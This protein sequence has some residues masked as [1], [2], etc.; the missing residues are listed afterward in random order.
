MR[1]NGGPVQ[2]L[3]SRYVDSESFT[4]WCKQII[5]ACPR[6]AG[7]TYLEKGAAMIDGETGSQRPEKQTST[8]IT[9]KT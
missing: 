6:A 7:A 4:Q 8:S 2:Y 3:T 1:A 5:G 9:Q